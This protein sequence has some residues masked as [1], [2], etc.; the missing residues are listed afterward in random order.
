MPV[1]QWPDEVMQYYRYDPEAA[2]KLLDEAGY[3]RSADGVRFKTIYEHFEYFDLG[4]YQIAMDYLRQIGIDVEIR[5]INVADMVQK[6]QKHTMLGMRS[7]VWGMA[8]PSVMGS[9]AMY[10]S[11]NGWRPPNVN[12]ALFDEYY[13][14]AAAATAI[15]EQKEWMR[16]ADMRLIEQQWTIRGP[17]VPLFGATQP[18]LKGY[19][20]ENELG[21]HQRSTIFQYLW[22]D[23]DLKRELGF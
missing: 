13:E 17:I 15:E 3:P 21:G 16:K 14:N 20:G 5:N 10:W 4:Y 2:E 12:D 18:W 9:L 23:Q 11:Q 7:D 19:N 22:V 6:A 1:E 8:H